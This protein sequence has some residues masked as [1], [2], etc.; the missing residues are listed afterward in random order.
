MHACCKKA[1]IP[2]KLNPRKFIPSK[3]THYTVNLLQRWDFC[4][5]ISSSYFYY[6]QFTV[7]YFAGSNIC[8]FWSLRKKLYCQNAKIR[9]QSVKFSADLAHS[10]WFFTSKIFI[11]SWHIVTSTINVAIAFC[12]KLACIYPLIHRMFSETKQQALQ[13]YTCY[14]LAK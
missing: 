6:W 14:T 3:Y 5:R 2:Q 8:K 11:Q 12:G 13:F 4:L 7:E 10:Q 9:Q 1:A